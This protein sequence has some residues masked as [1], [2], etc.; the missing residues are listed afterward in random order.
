MWR[1]A[2]FGTEILLGALEP[3][4]IGDNRKGENEVVG[5]S[6]VDGPF[7][8]T[9]NNRIF[10]HSQDYALLPA[11]LGP[12]SCTDPNDNAVRLRRVGRNRHINGPQPQQLARPKATNHLYQRR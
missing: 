2:E 11:N 6:E 8:Q 3:N 1:N 12:P 5:G 9:P 7:K 10:I 4:A